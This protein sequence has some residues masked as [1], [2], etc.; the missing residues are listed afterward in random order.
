MLLAILIAAIP[1]ACRPVATVALPRPSPALQDPD[2]RA[3]YEKRLAA[4]GRDV[5]A[6][7]ALSEW[8][9]ENG[10]DDER[11]AV[12]GKIIEVD[13]EHER[14]HKALR[15]HHYD[16]KWFTSYAAMSKYRREL[17][18]E[19]AAKG[20]G[21]FGDEWV[22][23]ADIPFLKMG[24]VKDDDGRWT[25]ERKL[26]A[27]VREAKYAAEGWQQQDLTWIPPDEFDKWRAGLLKCGD[28]WLSMEDANAYHSKLG[29]WW[30]IP[31]EHFIVYSTCDRETSDSAVWHADGTFKDLA[32][33]FGLQPDDKPRLAVV[34]SIAQYNEFAA[35]DQE[36]RRP[37]ADIDG[38]SSCHYAFYA[39]AW[40]ELVGGEPEYMS[41]G[42]CYWDTSDPNLAAFGRLA[43]KHAAAQSYVEA[44]DP[45]WNAVSAALASGGQ[46]FQTA[47]FWAEKKI[48]RWLRYGA[49]S[50]V[51]RFFSDSSVGEGGDPFQ[52][53]AWAIGNIRNQ[54][55]LR[56]LDEIFRFRLDPADPSGKLIAEAGLLVSF[57]LD[58]DCTP[59]E[60]AHRRFKSCLRSGEG[61]DLAIEALQ[62]TLKEH[63]DDLLAF[64]RL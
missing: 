19:M 57:M 47:E 48:P 40:Y 32:R 51:E 36:A 43:V 12:L 55:G 2:A 54:G 15:H 30:T 6:L 25:S 52:M 39:D 24:W 23:L 21:R 58:G 44:I 31:G 33:I 17:S 13:P 46:D 63:E 53:R 60:G 8:C 18:K 61:L 56:E 64:A 7:W 14:A 5:D 22:P 42:A 27:R 62:K 4:A 26:E 37:P 59:V 38:Y 28:E 20:L 9:K 1:T 49:A 50:Y 35:G 16:G 29:R 11:K 45:S 10:L 41:G 3:D 34:N